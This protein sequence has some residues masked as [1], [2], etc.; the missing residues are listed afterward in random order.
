MIEDRRIGAVALG[1]LR[2]VR[3]ALVVAEL[4]L[5]GAMELGLHGGAP[6]APALA[7]CAAV[8]VADRVEAAWVARHA[9]RRSAAV[10]PHLA[11]DLVALTLLVGTAPD[12]HQP[13]QV[14]F[15][16][17]SAV[18]AVAL[19]RSRALLAAGS[20]VGLQALL[21]LVAALRR[22]PE[23]P[24]L[25]SHGVLLGLATLVTTAF[26]G[27]LAAAL[28]RAEAARAA[29]DRLAALGTLA[30]G[31]AH[32]L[33]TPLGTIG[34]LV[35]EGLA[36][37]ATAEEKARADEGVR[38]QLDRCRLVLRRLK[39]GPGEMDGH[40]TDIGSRVA[41]W[42]REWAEANP[43]IAPVVRGEVVAPTVRGAADGWRAAVWNVL[44]NARQAG[45]SEPVEVRLSVATAGLP[46]VV[47]EVEDRGC[48][49]GEDALAR[50]GEPFFTG[51]STGHGTGLGLHTARTFARGVGGELTLEARRGG[52][53][54]VTLRLPV[55][56]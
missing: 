20:A 44:D 15:V 48:G 39:T 37:G 2:R 52:G 47:V 41:A 51:W 34:V 14:F 30:A 5:L 42:V 6:W 32:E 13:I 9:E 49:P 16:V 33:A 11:V 46:H 7:V 56:S 25:A 35:E 24:H 54:R 10:L 19:D 3:F 55:E 53:A 17:E 22:E 40:T 21:V 18:A 50:A 23:L 1:W 36:P 8:L 31:V 26:V 12:A 27:E 4:G 28:Q 45:G 43:G 29:S 38:D